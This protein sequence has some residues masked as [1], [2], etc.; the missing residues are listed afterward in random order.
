MSFLVDSLVTQYKVEV[1]RS[2]EKKVR[3][4]L[5]DSLVTQYEEEVERNKEKIRQPLHSFEFFA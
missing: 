2:K 3:Q 1:E 4:P 5:V